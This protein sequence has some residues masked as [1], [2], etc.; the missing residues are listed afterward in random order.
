MQKMLNRKPSLNPAQRIW[1][2]IVSGGILAGI[3]WFSN[4]VAAGQPQSALSLYA[5]MMLLRG[6]PPYISIWY[7]RLPG[8]FLLDAA[9]LGVWRSLLSVAVFQVLIVA[10]AAIILCRAMIASGAGRGAAGVWSGW[11]CV[12]VIAA[13]GLGGP[14]EPALMMLPFASGF[15]YFLILANETGEAKYSFISGLLAG[16][17][18]IF[19]AREWI[20]L[21]V[22]CVG[23]KRNRAWFLTGF[24]CLP[25]ISVVGLVA[26]GGLGAFY[27]STMLYEMS[28]LA[29]GGWRPYFEG[30]KT[31]ILLLI[32]ILA[33]LAV[34]FLH[35]SKFQDEIISLPLNQILKI[36]MAAEL[37]AL[38]LS[39]PVAPSM[40][41]SLLVPTTLFLSSR[42]C[43]DGARAEVNRQSE[44]LFALVFVCFASLALWTQTYFPVGDASKPTYKYDS[45][46]PLILGEIVSRNTRPSDRVL[47]W[48]DSAI[49]YVLSGR[50]SSSYYPVTRPLFTRSCSER[51][52]RGF[53]DDL[54]AN[55]PE[56]IVLENSLLPEAA[57]E[58][59]PRLSYM[60]IGP[61]QQP[62]FEYLQ[63]IVRKNYR[64]LIVRG[65][66]AVCKRLP[67][68]KRNR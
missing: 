15:I 40:I 20:L 64:I 6:K 49:A 5:A 11:F 51:T 60:E 17:V 43:L 22:G 44:V 7:D 67:K 4:L 53:I 21:F 3:Q 19:L 34:F 39:G 9:I 59:L 36:W 30:D 18:S 46:V 8:T 26:T 37:A 35:R 41:S 47:V 63:N 32:G 12:A 31:S 42:I 2:P 1:L 14:N 50:E 56:L 66:V 23:V 10:A 13:A 52:I 27:R 61:V 45:Q 38:F 28:V 16:A 29:G 54:R 24:M 55:P 57:V 65:G 33:P 48:G 68:L 25:L 58:K 62:V